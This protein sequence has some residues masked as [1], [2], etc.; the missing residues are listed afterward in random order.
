M[1]SSAAAKASVNRRRGG[2]GEGEEPLLN[3]MAEQW[4][5]TRDLMKVCRVCVCVRVRV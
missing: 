3:K 5:S 2:E 1:A 4:M